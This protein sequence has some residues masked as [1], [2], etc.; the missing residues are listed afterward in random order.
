MS[1]SRNETRP[2]SAM[3]STG[4]QARFHRSSVVLMDDPRRGRFAVRVPP[5]RLHDRANA[6]SNL[7]TAARRGVMREGA[8]AAT[9]EPERRITFLVDVVFI[10]GDGLEPSHAE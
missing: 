7:F 2:S 5:R 3:S 9:C 4:A 8:S 10:A 1:T 6:R